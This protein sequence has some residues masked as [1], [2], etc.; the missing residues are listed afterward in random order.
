MTS[1]FD[2]RRRVSLAR[3]SA[4]F[5]ALCI[6]ASVFVL[7]SAGCGEQNQAGASP[8][9]GS[10][11]TQHSDAGKPGDDGSD[12]PGDG[13]GNSAAPGDPTLHGEGIPC[14]VRSLMSKHCTL[15]HS[16]PPSFGAP[17]ALT[18]RD[19]LLQ[20]APGD[21]S[22][23]VYELAKSRIHDSDPLRRMPPTSQPPLT[24]DE[25][26]AFDAWLDSKV[27]ASDES[28]ADGP[29]EDDAGT[30][31][32]PGTSGLTCYKLLSHA[33]GDKTKPYH[34]GVARDQYLNFSFAPPWQGT[35][36]AIVLRP[37]VGNSQVIHHWL[38]FQE[39]GSV[40]DGAISGSNGAH[41]SGALVYSWTPGGTAI[42]LGAKAH[43]GLELPAGTGLTLE[44]HYNSD[45]D[46][47]EDASGVEICVQSKPPE[48]VAGVSWLGTDAILFTTSATG[49]CKPASQMPIHI[50]GDS[51]HMHL[52]GR[53]LKSVINR[54]SGGSTVIRDADFAFQDQGWYDADF[55]LMPGDTV[56]TTCSYDGPVSFGLRTV[57]EMCYLFTIAYPKGALADGLPT[58]TGAHGAGACL[59][60]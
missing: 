9:V 22:H 12:S 42:D 40:L 60:L 2:S 29:G 6:A 44:V 50:I 1:C 57:D 46:A 34:V 41:P 10:S 26:A 36:Y 13:E 20:S 18:S 16:S 8:C 33:A 39:L 35:A 38:L 48:N 14:A 49:T 11:C 51:P 54:A 7:S 47:A 30:P 31:K 25:L 28:C 3:P 27:A 53:H 32:P 45:S 15:C 24:S 23:K 21:G 43:A 37:I 4:R 55:T 59:G 17:M 52:K 19:A 56:T 58:G 5:D